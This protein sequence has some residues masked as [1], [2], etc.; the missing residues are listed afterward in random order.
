MSLGEKLIVVFLMLLMMVSVVSALSVTGMCNNSINQCDSLKQEHTVCADVSGDYAFSVDGDMSNWV[1]IAPES[2]YIEAD[3]CVDVY[4]FVTPECYANSGEYDYNI[5]VN[6]PDSTVVSCDL[7]VIQAHTFEFY[8][9]PVY[10]SSKPCEPSDYNIIVK[11]TSKF[12][13]E[14][15]LVQK[16]LDDSW[17]SYP[18]TKFVINPYSSFSA[19][20][21]VTS[22]CSADANNYPFELNLF[23]TKTNTSGKIDLVKNIV[24]FNPFLID[25]LSESNSFVLNSCEEFD[26]NVSFNLRSNSDKSDEL[27]F[28]LLDS[29]YAFLSKDKAYFEQTKVKLDYNSSSVVSLII[30]KGE[31]GVSDLIIKVNSKTYGKNYFYPIQVVMNNCYELGIGTNLIDSNSNSKSSCESF[32]REVINFY[33]NG[34][35]ELDFNAEFYVDGVLMNTQNVL[36]DSKS[37]VSRAFD[38]NAKA[39]PSESLIEVRVKAPFVEEELE[40]NYSFENCF[41]AALDI[42][43][44]LV[45]KNGYLTQEFT[46]K[47]E[48]SKR[49][50]YK[51]SIGSEWIRLSNSVF[52]L[53]S[54]DFVRVNLFGAV[55][56]EYSNE[57]TVTISSDSFT[58]SK[59]IP[60][61]TLSNEEC[62]ELN[63]EVSEVIDANCCEG[64]IIPLIIENNGYFAQIV[65]INPL[66][67]E[68]VLVSDSNLFMLPKTQSIVYLNIYPPA[69]T[70]GE[71]DAKIDLVTD[72]N[73][74]REVKFKVNVFGDNCVVPEGFNEDTNSKVSDLNGLKVTE[75]KFDFVISNDSNEEFTIKNIIVSD[76]NAVVKFESDLN[77]KPTE[78]TTAQII[79]WFS[80]SSPTDKNVSITIE[81]SNGVITKTQ[82]ISFKG[83]EQQVSITGW[84]GAYVAPLAGLIVFLL[85]V[86]IVVV[87]FSSSKKKS[88]GF[89]W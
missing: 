6:G 63:Y 15:V 62:N 74:Q 41:Q 83:E 17:V 5:R 45:C 38:F 84:F 68:W 39:I 87:L 24:R 8:A 57:E 50:Q 27:T 20:L 54:K 86:V 30:K 67:P 55:P 66:L 58:I 22:P 26:K 4:S 36:M 2:I 73:I 10:Q 35:E 21:R 23:N 69:G 13:D 64:T 52:D 61:I 1:K 12:V 88:K 18:Q 34:S 25:D 19:V 56:Q 16:G 14:F 49:A 81:T 60:V 7:R 29:N 76:L 44:I 42:S 46:V 37:S 75:V 31:V 47:N 53:N 32:A 3:S 59:T 40:Y 80:G 65:G 85:L 43:K 79:A 82:E 77:L 51:V 28:E 48:G 71:F 9:N 89:K 78:S 70:K 11:N 72:K 33:N